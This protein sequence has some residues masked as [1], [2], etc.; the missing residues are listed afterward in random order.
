MKSNVKSVRLI[1]LV[2]LL[3]LHH[4]I[5]YFVECASRCCGLRV[6]NEKKS[7]VKYKHVRG[8]VHA[9]GLQSAQFFKK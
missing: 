3:R 4:Y 8:R 1:L 5:I 2:S 9:L 7:F 6:K